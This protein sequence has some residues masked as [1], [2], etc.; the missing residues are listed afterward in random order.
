MKRL[1]LF[2]LLYSISVSATNY[3][4]K[5][6]GSDSNTGLSDA[7][8]WQTLTKVNAFT[9][10]IAGDKILFKRGDSWTGTIIP[11]YSATDLALTY[12]AYGTGANPI[13]TGFTSI[14]SGWTNEGGGIYSKVITSESQTN[15]VLINDVQYAMG[16]TP[17]TGLYNVYESFST[18]VSITDNQLTG[19]PSWTGAE[20]CIF[21]NGW[22]IDRCIVTNHTT[23]TITYTDLSSSNNIP[24]ISVSDGKYFFQNSLQTLDTYGEWYHDYA[25]TGKL[26]VYFGGVD[27]TTKIVKVATLNNLVYNA[28]GRSNL[29]FR[30]ISFVG[31][32][33]DIIALHNSNDATYILACDISYAGL[34][35][36]YIDGLNG[37]VD[38]CN[39]SYINRVAVKSLGTNTLITHNTIT[40]VGIPEAQGSIGY[41]KGAVWAYG[42]NNTISYNDINMTGYCGVINGQIP[43]YL[44]IS[45]N[46]I[47]NTCQ[48]RWDFGS[49]YLGYKTTG[50][51]AVT[52]FLVDHNVIIGSLGSGIYLDEYS[53]NFTATNNTVSDCA[54][55]GIKLHKSQHH[56]VTGNT[57]Y[58]CTTGIGLWNWTAEYCL[59][60]QTVTGNIVVAKY[61][62]QDV[63][64]YTDKYPS[65]ATALTT[66]VLNNNIYARPINDNTSIKTN[67]LSEG[68]ILRTLSGWKTYSSQDATSIISPFAV[69]SDSDIR[70]EYNET[71][72]P[73]TVVLDQNYRN[74]SI[75]PLLNNQDHTSVTLAP[76]TSIVLM[77]HAAYSSTSTRKTGMYNGKVGMING[78]AGRY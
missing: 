36:M 51:A 14:T 56:T 72:T 21:K 41:Y 4:V 27:P 77:K 13:I 50:G 28:N 46:Y 24:D 40:N 59:H 62:I 5:A 55:A 31:A 63:L 49:I 57:V 54:V 38:S 47:R 32:A 26:Y 6:S 15:M 18:N 34:D 78:K 12:G 17:N 20:A 16:R 8:A 19:S 33:Q 11:R 64:N 42:E 70:F 35:A 22:E 76:Y 66:Q 58:N 3:Y 71:S 69:S 45:Y 9:A 7:Q 39:I 48:D 1:I 68:T 61:A 74:L 37:R 30:D 23:T 67:V 10:F 60:D 52:S 65:A 44:T 43:Y 2:F 73:K 53:N 25:V 29:T 75:D